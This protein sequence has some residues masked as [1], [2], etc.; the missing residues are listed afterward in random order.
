MPA[1]RSEYQRI[2]QQLETE[3]FPPK[4]PG[5]DA[6]AF[7]QLSKEE[8][9]A[10]EKKRLAEYCR[11]AYKKTHVTKLEERYTTICQKENSFYVDTVR[12]FRDRRYTYKGLC[13]KAK[14]EVT[15]AAASG[16]AAWL[17][18]AKNKE[19]LYDSLQLAHKCI[20]NSFY[21]YVMRKGARWYSMEMAGIVCYTGAGIIKCAREL[22]EQIGRPL[23][24]DTDG[25]WC[26]M[27]ASFPENYEVK[28]KN[29]KKP[30]V[31]ISYPG[32][33]LN[34]MVQVQR[35]N[36]LVLSSPFLIK[37]QL[38]TS[39]LYRTSSLMTNITSCEMLTPWTMRSGLKIQFSLR[40]ILNDT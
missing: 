16:D 11:K 6:R 39:L 10:S 36:H 12:A 9:A 37:N 32:A 5:G 19:V 34:I 24:L 14:K 20:L 17:K 30:K 15:E 18:S 35:P 28:T 29:P 13:K 33:M 23:E 21:G 31:T 2:Q 38:L 1:G 25:I 22:I 4:F 8:Q 27:P 3:K 7:H 40:Y 26:I